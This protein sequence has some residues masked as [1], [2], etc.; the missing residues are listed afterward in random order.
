MSN[1]TQSILRKVLIA[2]FGIAMIYPLLWMIASSFKPSDEIFTNAASLVTARPTLDNYVTGWQGFSNHSF[3][4]FLL[5]SLLIAGLATIGTVMTSPFVAFG[6][7][8]LQFRG[9]GFWFAVMLMT[10]ML[11]YQIIMIPQYV[12]YNSIGWVGTIL[13]LVLPNFFAQA[14]FVFM[15]VQFIYAIPRELDQ[16]ARID[17]CSTF[18]V[19]FRIIF[20]LLKAPLVTA[21]I[22]SFMWK[23]DDFLGALLYLD[24]PSIYTVSI[25]LKLY[26]DPTAGTDWGAILAMSTIS[27]IPIFTLFLTGQK[28]LVEGISTEGLKM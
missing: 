15:I 19:Y 28:E 17:G 26:S 1:K 2:I 3:G 10:I 5:N 24:K 20:P 23:W 12:I 14:Y 18:G 13:P 22:L 7:A 16:S 4:R 25:A 27:I 21:A 9:R 11:P 6:F 8:R